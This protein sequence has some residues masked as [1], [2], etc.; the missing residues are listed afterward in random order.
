MACLGEGDADAA[1]R[2]LEEAL[3]LVRATGDRHD[4]AAAL[5]AMAQLHRTQNELDAA[6]PLY[7]QVLVLAREAGDRET[8]A[9]ALLN[10]AMASIGHDAEDRVPAMLLEVLDIAADIGSK[11][12]AQSVVEVSAGLSASRGDFARAATLFGVAEANAARTGLHRDPADE[13]FLAPLMAQAREALGAER[14]STAERAGRALG[15]AE[16]L[17]E[18][19]ACLS[20]PPGR[21]H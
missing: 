15:D 17:D 5:N 11:P 3:D 10:L 13:A 16:A 8:T 14:F 4:L 19:R 6:I 20:D 2:H 12:A 1:R 18:V 9:I 7:E 21:V